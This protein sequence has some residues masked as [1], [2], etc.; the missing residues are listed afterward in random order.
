[1]KTRTKNVISQR[2]DS[3]AKW[4]NAEYGLKMKR[5]QTQKNLTRKKNEQKM[6]SKSG[7]EEEKTPIQDYYLLLL[8][9]QKMNDK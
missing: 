1:M 4:Q 9:K 7:A 8:P 3:H 2:F 6:P 5:T